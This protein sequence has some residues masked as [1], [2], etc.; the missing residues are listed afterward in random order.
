MK[1]REFI[2]GQCIEYYVLMAMEDG[3]MQGCMVRSYLLK[4]HNL[5]FT[6][7]QISGAFQRLKKEGL[8]S[9]DGRWNRI[10]KGNDC[11]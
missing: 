4:R 9:Y 10:V 6:I 7:K 3:M 2:E 8:A 1:I 11:E 5:E